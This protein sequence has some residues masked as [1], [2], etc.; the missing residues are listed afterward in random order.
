MFTITM[1]ARFQR[2]SDAESQLLQ[3]LYETGVNMT[4]IAEQLGRSISSIRNKVFDLRLE[5]KRWPTKKYEWTDEKI[6]F[7]KNN[8][9]E[10]TSYDIAEIIGVSPQMVRA[11]ARRLGL[12]LN[13][14]HWA[15][16]K[17]RPK[18]EKGIDLYINQG[19]SIKDSAEQAGCGKTTLFKYL[20]Q[21][22]LTREVE[23]QRVGKYGEDL[24]RRYCIQK[25][26]WFRKA[27]KRHTYDYFLKTKG[28][29][30]K[31][32]KQSMSIAVSNLQ[33]MIIDDEYWFF[34]EGTVYKLKFIETDTYIECSCIGD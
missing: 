15:E 17:A 27:P 25:N 30:V 16:K 23:S 12:K 22:G 13:Y 24:C 3:Q 19:L 10:I 20:T 2:W 9:G 34:H 1:K 6:A 5:R 33:K 21:L 14:S 29:N 18:I 8:Y 32:G 4:D 26:I 31:H 28:I 7:I 11:R